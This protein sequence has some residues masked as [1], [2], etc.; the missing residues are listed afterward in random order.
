MKKLYTYTD[1]IQNITNENI[2][3]LKEIKD[4]D[5]NEVQNVWTP[6]EIRYMYELSEEEKWTPGQ[7]IWTPEE[8]KSMYEITKDNIYQKLKDKFFERIAIILTKD[9]D[10][11]NPLR[12]GGVAGTYFNTKMKKFID[13]TNTTYE[14]IYEEMQTAWKTKVFDKLTSDQQIPNI[15]NQFVNLGKINFDQNF[16]I[17]NSYDLVDQVYK[18]SDL[19][20]DLKD[21]AKTLIQTFL[22]L[23]NTDNDWYKQK[24]NG[25][26]NTS[27]I[28]SSDYVT[29]IFVD[30]NQKTL[31]IFAGYHM[32]MK[33]E[34]YSYYRH[35]HFWLFANIIMSGKQVTAAT[36]TSG[37][38]RKLGSTS[39]SSATRE[40]ISVD[41][42]AVG[43]RISGL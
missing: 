23:D 35:Y 8:I 34:F 36:T 20:K 14:K 25:I 40:R 5:L 28:D 1:F 37:T 31:Q 33:E 17:K 29:R 41:R 12:P 2:N 16:N 43:E 24:T 9:E 30:K 38:K 27:Q 32:K 18:G 22:K 7:K 42:N 39:T 10:L 19:S 13:N 21:T 6:E 26:I 4:S 15:C 11:F 3:H